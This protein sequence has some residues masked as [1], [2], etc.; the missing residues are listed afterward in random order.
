MIKPLAAAVLA[1]AFALGVAACSAEPSAPVARPAPAVAW[2]EKPLPYPQA[3]SPELAE[4]LAKQTT[5]VTD[6]E[7]VEDDGSIINPEEHCGD[8]DW[9][10]SRTEGD[11]GSYSMSKLAANTRLGLMTAVTRTVAFRTTSTRPI[12]AIWAR[13]GCPSA[14][15]TCLSQ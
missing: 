1:T 15:V 5:P 14:K 2:P 10:S 12:A 6:E 7:Y 4:E 11:P 8:V 13:M 3:M 9:W